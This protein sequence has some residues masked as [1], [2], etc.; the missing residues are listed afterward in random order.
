M[1]SL[2]SDQL[3]M[4][5]AMSGIFHGTLSQAQ[6]VFEYFIQHSSNEVSRNNGHAGMALLALALSTPEAAVQVIDMLEDVSQEVTAIRALIYKMAK[7]GN[8]DTH[9]AN[10]EKMGADSSELAAEIRKI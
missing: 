7:N 9:L 5:L 4:R 8:A 3:M 10:L 1:A 2:S 6:D